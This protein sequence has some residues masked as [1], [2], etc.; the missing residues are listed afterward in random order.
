[1]TVLSENASFFIDK[2]DGGRRERVGIAHS[3]NLTPNPSPN[4]RGAG[5]E[6]ISKGLTSTRRESKITLDF[7]F[8][9]FYLYRLIQN[10][11]MPF[12]DRSLISVERH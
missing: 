5:G 4:W 1:L 8:P 9:M 12:G 6:V 3:T 10:H 2:I 7:P 11:L